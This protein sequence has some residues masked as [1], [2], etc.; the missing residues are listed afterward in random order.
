MLRGRIPEAKAAL[1][2]RFVP[3]LRPVTRFR[4]DS[5]SCHQLSPYQKQVAEGEQREELGAVLGEA[6]VAGLHMAKLAFDDKAG[7]LDPGPH[8][9]D[10]A[11]GCFLHEMQLAAFRGLA[12]DTPK[13]AGAIKCG[14]A[15]GADI[16]LA[17]PDR[18]FVTMQHFVPDPA[19]VMMLQALCRR[20]NSENRGALTN[21]HL[22]W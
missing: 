2:M 6:A 14:F 4:A 17:D 7:M 10:D 15:F 21:T 13:S 11:V 16:A 18:G 9:G 5:S 22:I 1:V 19:R 12:H 3:L 20:K 8:L